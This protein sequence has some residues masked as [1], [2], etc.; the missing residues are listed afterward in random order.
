MTKFF[1][2]SLL[3]LDDRTDLRRLVN[4]LRASLLP[5]TSDSGARVCPGST[6]ATFYGE[7]A[8]GME[9]FGRPL[10][11]V[12]AGTVYGQLPS[13][14]ESLRTAI[15]AGIDPEHQDYWGELG[16]SD[17]RSVEMA[18]LGWGLA[19]AP[20]IWWDPLAERDQSRL[21]RWLARINDVRL[22]ANNWRFFRLLVNAGLRRV[23]AQW[24]Q[25]RWEEDLALIESCYLGDGW[26]S[27][28]VTAQRDY[29]IAMA[30]HF[31][32][33]LIA[34]LEFPEL[35][36]QNRAYRARAR[37]F[38]RDFILW[39]TPD[40]CALPYGRSLT[41]R[42]AQ[43]AFWSAL[44]WCGEE[45]LPWGVI[46]GLLLRHLRWWLAQPI[47]TDAGVLTIGYTYPNLLMSDN[48][49]APASP[50]WAMKALLP[51]GLAQDHPFWQAQELPLPGL[52]A[53]AIQSHAGF[54]IRRHDGGH[55][56]VLASGQFTGGWH[57]RHGAEK[58]SKFA[59]STRF[60][61][62]VPAGQT[63][64]AD[65]AHDNTLALSEEGHYWRVRGACSEARIERDTLLS[66]WSV[67]PDV[68]LRTWLFFEGLWQVRV[69]RLQNERPLL[70][71][72]A[73]HAL[74]RL[75]MEPDEE[76]KSWRAGRGFAAA[77]GPY[78]VGGIV[79][80]TGT[81]HGEVIQ[82]SANTNLLH[83][84]TV[85]PTLHGEHSPGVHW[86]VSLLP[87]SHCPG[88]S[89]GWLRPAV[90]LTLEAEALHLRLPGGGG[91]R[92]A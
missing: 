73:G 21:A 1:G 74:P 86:L 71:A 51:A 25:A 46:K 48:Y 77:I 4:G 66:V 45:A 9:G 44:A 92:F 72:E 79:D 69:H 26:Y 54:L 67:W 42:F 50:Y 15:A 85:L 32:G 76:R 7:P 58:Y 33:L 81:R 70:S 55:I 40:G 34:R 47:F 49:N 38:A 43:G 14:I 56:T 2:A 30:M 27:D 41:Y 91:R 22:P 61:F 65:G 31:Y 37:L 88:R 28:G 35:A 29:Y 90:E 59:Y 75:E 80:P 83:P 17:Q 63:T 52:P 12:I 24:S 3:P 18:V 23:G 78:N 64:L 6:R 20:S 5:F 16:D 87:I 57:L 10:W 89:D 82:P 36:D 19:A 84:R 62:S 11:P 53:L 60:G 8:T 68:H 39:F 13:D